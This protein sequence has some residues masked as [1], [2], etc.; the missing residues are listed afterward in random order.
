MGTPGPVGESADYSSHSV[1]REIYKDMHGSIKQQ[2]E[3]GSNLG[4]Y[5]WK[6]G[7]INYSEKHTLEYF[8]TSKGS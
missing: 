4:A 7:Y 2:W 8:A 6:N 1:A 5:Y 3:V